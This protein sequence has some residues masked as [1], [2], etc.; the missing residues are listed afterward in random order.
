VSY[1]RLKHLLS[2]LALE[3]LDA[4]DRAS[5]AAVAAAYGQLASSDRR[6]VPVDRVV[7]QA[8]LVGQRCGYSPADSDV[9]HLTARGLC[10]RAGDALHL[11]PEFAPYLEYYRRQTC[12][13]MRALERAREGRARDPLHRAA[14]L[15]EAGLYFECHELLEGVWRTTSGP[16]RDFYHGLIQVAAAFYHAEKGNWHGA[17]VLVDKGLHKLQRYPDTYLGVDVR[18][19]V[20]RLQPWRDY[21]QAAGTGPSPG[22]R[23]QL[24]FAA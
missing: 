21:F 2:G 16:Q 23:P 19:L 13:L 15:L 11:R 7:E 6:A 20:D 4:P 5:W 8:R 10:G 1:A 22:R 3:A 9:A 14:I 12:R 17:R 18:S 24:T